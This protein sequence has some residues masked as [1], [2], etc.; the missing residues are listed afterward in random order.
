MLVV[1]VNH[2][3][4]EI[5]MNKSQRAL[6]VS[7]A[8][9]YLQSFGALA[10]DPFESCPTQA[11]IVQ[12]P[13]AVPI[14]YGVD[15][16]IGSYSTLS[17]DM[18]TTKVNGVGFSYHDNY[19]YGWDYGSATLSQFGA[20]YQ[21]SAL[22]VSGLI[23]KP[24]YVGDVSV[25][26][27]AWYGYRSSFGLYRV[28]LS[29]PA[30]ALVMEQVASSSSMGNPSLTD[31]AFHPYDGLIYAVD[32]N[33]YLMSINPATGETIVLV[34]VL[35]EAEQGFNFTFGAQYFDV[36]GNLYL[37]NN[38][39]GYVYR[40]TLNG[41]LSNAVFFT[42]GPS[43]NSND[44]A[45]CALA[46]IVVSDSVDFGD[47]P[48]SYG[49]TLAAA[50]ARHG[51]SGLYLGSIVDGESQAYVYPLSDDL[52]DESDDDDGI[53]FP[54]GFEIGGPSLII[55]N[56]T[57]SG[58]FLNAWIDWDMDGEFEFDEQIV[59]NFS[60]AEGSNNLP[61]NVPIWATV[62]DTW[63]RFR[64]STVADIGPTGGVSNGEVEDYQLTVTESGVTMSYY[65]SATGYTS[66]AFEDL[67]PELGDFD[68]NDVLMNVRF[69]EYVKDGMVIRL[70]IE[71][72]LAALGASYRNG[73]AIQLPAIDSNSVK[74]DS[75]ALTMDN[76]R[77]THTLLDENQTN[78]VLI[79]SNNL[80][81]VTQAGEAGC[82][83]FRVE[84]G[85]GTT[86]RPSWTMTVPF[87]SPVAQSSMPA[88]PYDPFIFA[89]PATYHGDIVTA[90]TGQHPGRKFEV[91]L[92]NHMPSDAF[93]KL[94]FGMADDASDEDLQLLF[95]TLNGIPWALEIPLEW[96]HPKESVSLLKAYPQFFDFASDPS[97]QTNPEWYLE[98]NANPSY[99]YND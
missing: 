27:N 72:K 96:K 64:I 18:G 95:Q 14:L 75:I 59:E 98:E 77:Q 68:M 9:L 58:G 17:S 8:F 66:F 88:M 6:L 12:T 22:N 35:S 42:Y 24:F 52:S 76:I 32:N 47:A 20:D 94:I 71:G 11:F 7:I 49:S 60:V 83:Y 45:R 85:C 56:V 99:L 89:Q 29:D 67:Y 61:V 31:M 53:S 82:Y 34:Q 25:F 97:G 84:E 1:L 41:V 16:A 55:A 69:T 87:L 38:S 79:V 43:S 3:I 51:I 70:K 37:S 5:L 13:G 63:A 86:S 57:G 78:A 23:G 26:E 28:D 46:E 21:A 90:V 81:D 19:M 80:W 54:T 30:S 15:L 73:F 36:D 50:G 4:G 2:S 93:E 48:D 39:N 10:A 44:G 74:G 92:K 65:P 91:H 40:V 62:G 33:G